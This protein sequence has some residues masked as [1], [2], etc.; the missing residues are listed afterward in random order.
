MKTVFV[1]LVRSAALTGAIYFFARFTVHDWQ[2]HNYVWAV[3]SAA[4]LLAF[5]IKY[6]LGYRD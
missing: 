5:S 4:F 3:F 2:A 1:S 6:A